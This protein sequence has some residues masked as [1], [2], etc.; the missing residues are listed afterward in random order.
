MFREFQRFAEQRFERA[1]LIASDRMTVD[2]KNDLRRSMSGAGLGRLGLAI[3]S[4]SDIRKGGRVARRGAGFSASGW[5]YIR[6][7]SER[8]VGAIQA[9]TEGATISPVKGRWLWIATD[10]IPQRVGKFRMTPQRYN[11]S[12]LV[13]SIGP[14][15]MIPGRNSGEALLVVRGVTTRLAGRPNAR[16]APRSGRARAGREVQDFVVAFVGIRRTS[17]VARVNVE[18]IINGVVSRGADYYSA[19]LGTF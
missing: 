18:T 19:A 9:Y 12:G 16:R 1:A 6:S 10:S 5:L 2:A 8:T 4:G 13:N 17:R 14:L 15:V 11:A 7:K 3:G